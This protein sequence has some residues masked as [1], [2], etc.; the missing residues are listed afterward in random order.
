[1]ALTF[2]IQ[3]N[4]TRGELSPRMHS[5]IDVDHY[6]AGLHFCEN[7][8]I[9]REGGLRRRGGFKMVK[10]VKNSAVKTRLMPFVFGTLSTGPQAYVIEQGNL[11]ARFIT[12][13]GIITSSTIGGTPTAI[14]Q[15]N[16]GVVT[17]N[18][19]GLVNGDPVYATGVGGMVELNNREF[20]VAGATANTFQLSG[21]NTTAY[22]AFTAGGSI[23]KIVELTTPYLTADLFGIDYAQSAD[24]MLLTHGMYQPIDV[25]RS[26]DDVW[27]SSNPT[28]KD[29]PYLDE[30]LNNTN[31]V[32]P[33]ITNAIHPKM[34]SN[35]LPS[36]TVTASLDA[37]N[38]YR[39]FDQTVNGWAP[40]SSSEYVQYALAAG[41][42]VVDHYW[43][44]GSRNDGSKAPAA[45]FLY[46]WDGAA[47][48]RIDER[49][50]QLSWGGSEKRFFE[51][52]NTQAYSIYRFDVQGINGGSD[53]LVTELNFGYNGD[54]APT[55]TLTFDTTANIN[56]GAGFSSV[57]GISDVGRH[58]R[59]RPSDGKW[60][61]FKI[62]GVTSPTVV[63]GRMYGYGLADLTKITRW[64]LGAWYGGQWP[65]KV[66]FFQARRAHA[67]STKEPYAVWLSK[68]FDFF[69]FGTSDPLVEDDGIRNVILS[70]ELNS[71]A[72]LEGAEE[73]TIGTLNN[74]RLMQ[75]S[76]KQEGFSAKNQN[77][78]VQSF[79]GALE[80]VKPARVG[81]ALLFPDY[82]ARSIREFIY[83]INQD[84]YTAPDISVL[85]RHL[86]KS[87]IVDMAY[88]KAPDSIL[89]IVTN[90]GH[91]VAMTY[92]REQ[93]I[94][95]FT[96]VTLAEGDLGT[97]AVVESVCCIPGV[98]RTELYII[99]KRTIGGATKRYIER[100]ASEW[101]EDDAIAD[102]NFLDSSL[103]YSGAAVGTL[104][105]FFHLAGQLVDVLA[106]GIVYRDVAITATGSIT[107]PGAPAPTAAKWS[108]GK[109]K[110]ALIRPL[111]L[112]AL[113]N[114]GVL[115]G[116]KI[117]A[118][119][120][121]LSCLST[122]G[123][124]V[125][126]L[127]STAYEVF[128]RDSVLDPS[129]GQL[130]PRTGVFPLKFDTSWADKG[131]FDIYIDDP[132]PA[133]V[134][135]LVIGNE[136]EP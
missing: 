59:L 124:Y 134:R 8:I 22:G 97:G 29:G 117:I 122:L 20:T 95:G 72:W 67:R 17:I 85:S 129:V 10:E 123:L 48:V 87:G 43:V 79:D 103:T 37:A 42:A 119:E 45:W 136:K 56:G 109:R 66:S 101:D 86:L 15:A 63:T 14:T 77:Q 114:D 98:G 50:N 128:S 131:Q 9:M 64:K 13:G 39:V 25:T 38:G 135:G 11:Y 116:R 111:P 133:I 76:N 74:I 27:T 84:G 60:R 105:G 30:P 21:I 81:S 46:G 70:G 24:T 61:W 51:F 18:A 4:F 7:F 19:H 68:A 32:T 52:V 40:N 75:Q 41:S 99:V 6:K 3:A 88:Q 23:R 89:W 93:K 35:T 121:Y 104:T 47:F 49:Y 110:R 57:A 44:T 127:S 100:L 132:L 112:A 118:S 16:P 83:E 92:E 78:N 71:I 130:T 53:M 91:L 12:N 90:A 1:M 120:V 36:G 34:T 96:K 106:D 82:Y 54:Y 26:A 69:D 108:V 5:R 2:P 58:I 55:M 94:L 73:L 125:K 33:S 107:L 102:A 126:G 113:G 65:A 62:T 28:F 115:I 80:L 31:G